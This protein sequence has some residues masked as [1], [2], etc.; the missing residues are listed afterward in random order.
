MSEHVCVFWD[1]SNIFI[2]AKNVATINEGWA[3]THQLRI[4]FENLYEL[5]VAGRKVD[6]AVCVGSVP[7]ELAKVWDR[8]RATGVIVELYERGSES[9]TE[10]GVDQ[11][12]Q[13]HMLRAMVDIKPPGVAVLVTGDG[14]GYES[15]RG[16]YADLERMHKMGWGVE[17]LSWDTAVNKRLKSWAEAAGAYVKLDDFY[18]FITFRKG[19][20]RAKAKTHRRAYAHPQVVV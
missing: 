16:F 10:Q 14:K 5:A 13:V 17:L 11:C 3:A 18:E 15:G 6:R 7:P 4:E 9:G 1:N 8:L 2:A 12:L 20:R 19:G